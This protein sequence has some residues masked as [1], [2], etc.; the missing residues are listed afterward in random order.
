[1]QKTLQDV[2]YLSEEQE[3]LSDQVK[4][5]QREFDQLRDLAGQQKS[6]QESTQ[7]L[8]Q[9]LEELLKQSSSIPQKLSQKLGMCSNQMSQAASELTERDGAN[10]LSLQTEAM[11]NLNEIAKDLLEAVNKSCNNPSS[12]M[13][14]NPSLSQSLQ[15]LAQQ[16][17]GINQSTEDYSNMLQEMMYPGQ[18]ELQGLAQEQAGVQKSLE[19]L[20]KEQAES[21]NLLGRLDKLAVEIK[22]AVKKLEKGEL[23][24]ELKRRQHRILNRLLDAEKSLYTQ[25]FS[26][27]RKA[28]TGEDVLRKSPS[29]LNLNRDNNTLSEQEK[30]MLEKYPPQY[31]EMIKSYFRAIRS[32]DNR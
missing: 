20:F 9:N 24:E 31:E 8:N 4:Q 3:K 15:N 28:E 25:D 30:L 21:S 27:Q 1:M 26:N 23:D 19:E 11:A 2:L 18:G 22:E 29:A 5:N 10:A 17:Q 16:Q 12:G 13:C 6:L 32:G 7:K 14:S